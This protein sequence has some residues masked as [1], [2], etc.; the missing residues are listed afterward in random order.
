MPV[1]TNILPGPGTLFVA[2][3]GQTYNI[4]GQVTASGAPLT[5]ASVFMTGSKVNS[6]LTTADGHYEFDNLPAGGDYTITAVLEGYSFAPQTITNLQSNQVLNV[7]AQGVCTYSLSAS[8]MGIGAAGGEQHIRVTTDNGCPWG[9]NNTAPWITVTRGT[10]NGSGD[11]YFNAQPSQGP[12]RVT[13]LT[14]A[15]QQFTVDQANGCTYTFSGGDHSFPATGGASSINVT[16]SDGQCQ[17]TPGATDYCMISSLS[18]G[19]GNGP[20]NF[21]VSNN[22]GVARSGIIQLGDQTFAVDQAAAP[23]T[24]R[25]RFDF[26][27][28]GKADVSVF[29]P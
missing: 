9:V 16:A 25:T 27:G 17:W 24:H 22:H 12:E 10:G 13:T 8:Q 26:D 15:G 23:G 6:Y 11:M 19:T 7:S 3:T 28:D 5:G 20:L 14:V 2:N 29:R 1:N 21:S 4:S 18:G